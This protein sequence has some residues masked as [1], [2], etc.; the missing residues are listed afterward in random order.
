MLPTDFRFIPFCSKD[1]NLEG[2]PMNRLLF[3]LS[4]WV[5][6]LFSANV[7]ASAKPECDRVCL[8][9]FLNTYLQAL[10]NNDASSLP[11]TRN[12]KYTENGVRLNLD[13]G[14]WHT[15]SGLPVY[16]V[17][18]VDEEAESVGMLGIIFENGNRHFFAT[19]LKV[20]QGKKISQIENLVVRNIG[21]SRFENDKRNDPLP[22]FAQKIPKGKRLSRAQLIAIGNSYFT[23]LDTDN[24]G[25]NVP[26]DPNC[27]RR[28][29]GMVTANSPD[30]KAGAMQKMDCKAQFDT[31]F[32][33]IVTDIRERRFIAD[34]ERGLA[35]AFGYFDHNGS[36]AAYKDLKTGKTV[37]V[38]P[39]FR[40][41]FSF[42]IA[43]CFKVV[44]GKIRQIEAVLTTVPYEMS[45]GW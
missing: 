12:V 34:P 5:V 28:E 41:P 43:E 32:S 30:P 26:F 18:I 45:S 21:G 1:H 40:Q 19:R 9:G 11:V 37:E 3:N 15:V 38:S 35:F 29:N 24:N 25:S 39:I 44:D 14:L 2:E 20:E 16:R 17:N 7:F 6:F 42:Y 13:D 33:V 27:Q 23:G 8:T 4:C 31:G 10:K 22:I 36:V